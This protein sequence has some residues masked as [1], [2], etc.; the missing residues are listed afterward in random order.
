MIA[1]PLP[2]SEKYSQNQD[3]IMK[4]INQVERLV[5]TRGKALALYKLTLE[6]NNN[7]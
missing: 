6:V 4:K 2:K 3:S 7:N 5:L 1:G